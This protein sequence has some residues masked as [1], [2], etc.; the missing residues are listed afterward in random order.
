MTQ[1]QYVKG[2]FHSYRALTKINFGKA[3]VDVYKDEIIEFDGTTV[4]IGGQDYVD[5][6]VRGA[7]SAG[8]FVPEADNISNYVAKKADIRLRPAGNAGAKADQDSV[9]TEM[10]DEEREVGTLEATKAKRLAAATPPQLRQPAADAAPAADP[11]A[12]IAALMAQVQ[13]LQ[14]QLGGQ[15]A[16]AAA[17]PPKASFNVATEDDDYTDTSGQGAVPVSR[18]KTAAVQNFK[19]DEN[20]IRQVEQALQADGKPLNVERLKVNPVRTA[21]SVRLSPDAATGD[22]LESREAYDVED[23]LPNAVKGKPKGKTGIVNTE[24]EDN[25]PSTVVFVKASDGTQIPWDKSN[26]WKVRIKTALAKYSDDHATLKAIIAIEDAGVR[27]ELSK[28][29]GD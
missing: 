7:I 25:H 28:V 19:A 22:V 9:I 29:V 15:A 4:K 1:I 5:S 12:Q 21:K 2:Q 16:T 23:L 3:G 27:K 6:A 11:M 26:H 18:I 20:S 10:T 14:A 24:G 8:W 17:A 13:A